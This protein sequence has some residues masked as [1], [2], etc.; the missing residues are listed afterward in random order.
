MKQR[1][2]AALLAVMMLLSVFAF[3]SCNNEQN[4]N[5]AEESKKE[6]TPKE[7]FAA[8]FANTFTNSE[9]N[10]I[11]GILSGKENA[12]DSVGSFEFKIDEL[13]AEGQDLASL[14]E[15]SL[16]A[17]ISN[18]ADTEM[19]KLDLVLSLF[20]EKPTA[21]IVSDNKNQKLYI[22]DLLGV[23]ENPILFE[24]S[25]QNNQDFEIANGVMMSQI[26]ET[27]ITHVVTS[28]V[29]AVEKNINDSAYTQ[30]IK[31]VTVDGKSFTGA[32]VITLTVTDETAKAVASDFI[33]AVLTNATV[34]ALLGDDFDKEEILSE[35]NLPT[36]VR[37]IN[38]VVDEKS[39]ALDVEIDLPEEKSDESDDADDAD[40]SEEARGYNKVVIHTAYIDGN[41]KIDLGPVDENGNYIDE[42]GYISAA[43]T[44]E[45]GNEKF[46]LS[47][48][49]NG[50]TME[51]IKMEGTNKDGKREG[52]ITVS[53]DEN[54]FVS[55]NYECVEKENS[56]SFKIHTITIAN[57]GT[58][59]IIPFEI[60]A[61]FTASETALTMTGTLKLYVEGEF[62][63]S[64]SMS[65]NVEYKDVTIDEV[66][67]AVSYDTVDYDA[68]MDEIAQKYP[69]ISSLLGSI[70]GQT[71]EAEQDEEF[72]MIT[73]SFGIWLPTE[74]EEVDSPY[75]NAVFRSGEVTVTLVEESF[76]SLSSD[77]LT[78][79]EYFEL[80][81][82]SNSNQNLSEI[83]DNDGIPY[84]TFEVSSDPG[85]IYYISACEGA[86]SFWIMQFSCPEEDYPEYE[87]LFHEW[88]WYADPYADEW[89]DF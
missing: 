14:G 81:Y 36:A 32:K 21:S 55:I 56:G 88:A 62:G 44:L 3:A 49:E 7:L 68:L 87:E 19:S 8:S 84:M 75:Y 31:D 51:P 77:S 86:D 33:D 64:A 5:S 80:L 50:E 4:E 17:D 2:F 73:D 60:S 30:E 27:V 71:G 82:Q 28:M 11:S 58:E 48:Y 6:L 23:L 57:D 35:D 89:V 83:K 61:E 45:D 16:K 22:T 65:A 34:K 66:T 10:G 40:E 38:T 26:D 63:I 72:H 43:Y 15:L 1:I 20:G 79:D 9:S 76:S 37:V 67:D 39:V 69:M 52:R 78:L 59:N 29:T 54:N 18:D 70:G 53:Q 24:T 25:E 47:I 41:Y 12:K 42:E 85:Y 46:V 74:F 13:E